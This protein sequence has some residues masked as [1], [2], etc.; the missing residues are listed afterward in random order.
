MSASLVD[1]EAFLG[2][3]DENEEQYD[4]YEG[5]TN[6]NVKEGAGTVGPYVDS[7]EEDEED[8]DDEEAARAVSSAWEIS[9]YC[10][11]SSPIDSPFFF[12]LQVREGF[13][14]DEDEEIEERAQRRREKRKRRREERER[15]DE[16]LDAE[17]LELIGELNPDFQPPVS[18]E[19]RWIYLTSRTDRPPRPPFPLWSNLTQSV[20]HCS[21]SSSA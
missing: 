11:P 16:N 10:H 12:S 18:A 15:E 8:E 4:D 17:D 19:V 3:E 13:I 14:V 1:N 6:G 9:F 2:S 5:N 7:S 21:P 20:F